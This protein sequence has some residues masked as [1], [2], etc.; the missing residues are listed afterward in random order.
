MVINVRFIV[1]IDVVLVLYIELYLNNCDV[2]VIFEI[3]F[4]LNFLFYFICLKDYLIL[5]KDRIDCL[6]GGVVIICRNDC[7]LE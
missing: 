2:C 3:W 1:K 6:G 4:K 7:L 5:L